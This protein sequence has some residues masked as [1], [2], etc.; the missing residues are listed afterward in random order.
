M[1]ILRNK[2][3]AKEDNKLNPNSKNK[4]VNSIIEEDCKDCPENKK[5]AVIEDD[6]SKFDKS[7]IYHGDGKPEKKLTKKDKAKI[8]KEVKT[9]Q[10]NI[11]FD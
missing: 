7:G 6:L 8:K 10:F 4:I 5:D 11:I 9:G 1:L 2:L 3:F